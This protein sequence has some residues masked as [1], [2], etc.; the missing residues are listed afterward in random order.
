MNVRP[1]VLR[2]EIILSLLI[3]LNQY[4]IPGRTSSLIDVAANGMGHLIG[5][6]IYFLDKSI[7]KRYS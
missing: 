4:Y 7:L 5:M 6:L 1:L 3:E 2:P